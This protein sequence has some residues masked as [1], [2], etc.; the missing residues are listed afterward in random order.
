MAHLIRKRLDP[1]EIDHALSGDATPV[2]Q[3]R[4]WIIGCVSSGM[5][6]RRQSTDALG[7][8]LED[9][10]A[11]FARDTEQLEERNAEIER[12]RERLRRIEAIAEETIRTGGRV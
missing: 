3:S 11:L 12:L 9:M 2:P 1:R 10:R 7:E 8:Q 4:M 6:Q 5:T